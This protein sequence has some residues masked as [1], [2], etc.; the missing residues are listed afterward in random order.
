MHIPDGMVPGDICVAGL[1]GAAALTWFCVKKAQSTYKDTARLVSRASVMA[2]VF[3]V[4]SW[5][6]IPLPPVS[7]HPVLAGLMGILLGWISFPAI[8]TGLFFQA[9]M[10]GHGG[11][12]T[13]GI[14]SLSMGGAALLAR[15]L[16]VLLQRKSGERKILVAGF[17]AG[18]AGVMMAVVFTCSFLIL[19]LPEYINTKT[20]ISSILGMSAAH[21]PLALAE[22]VFTALVVRF[23]LRVRPDMLLVA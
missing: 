21:L 14:N 5:I 12:T 11:F 1:A 7:V 15:G 22:G 3:F 17:V 9:V 6:H 16:F 8:L 18:F 13:I 19:T 2:A 4:V 23:I 20:E 10:F